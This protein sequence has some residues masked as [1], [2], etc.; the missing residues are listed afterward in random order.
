M[1]ALPS[2]VCLGLVRA[3]GRFGQESFLGAAEALG[4]KYVVVARL[5]KPIQTLCRHQDEH[6]QK[7][8]IDGLE[9]QEAQTGQVGR[10]LILM[11]QRISERPQ[12]GGKL[13]LAVP[14][15]RFQ[16]LRT[17]RGPEFSALSVWRR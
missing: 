1:G 8:E 14:G 15:Y 10:R 6:W 11:R 7:T 4:L 2:H 16:A 13:L 3:D 5:I 17:N 9:V 12:S